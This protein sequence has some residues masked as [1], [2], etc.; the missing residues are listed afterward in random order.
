[1][2]LAIDIGNTNITIGLFDGKGTLVF[3]S[4]LET[5]K[6]KTRDQCCIDLLGVFQLYQADI[7]K[8]KGAILSSVV[9]P[10][11]ANMSSAVTQLI[12]RKPLLVGPGL[13]TGMN[14]KADVQNQLGSDIVASSVAAFSKYETPIIVINLG[15]AI[16]FSYLSEHSYEGCSITPGIQVALE[17]L[18]ERAAQLPHISLDGNVNPLGR[19]TVDAMRA[20]VIFGNAGAIDRMID[21]M[22]EAAGMPVKTIVATGDS[23]GHLL[24]HCR[25]SIRLDNHL[26]MDGLFLLY[27]KNTAPNRKK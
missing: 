11:T 4:E 5:D 17:A 21:S 12:G 23:S 15:T 27:Q 26:L 24:R 7:S 8:V 13:R 6:K 18:S 25:H 9:P 1:M 19:N 14:I 10:M 22:E 3:L 20:G 16:T 2:V